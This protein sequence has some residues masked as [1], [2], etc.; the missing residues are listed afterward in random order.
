MKTRFASLF[1]AT[2]LASCSSPQPRSARDVSANGKRV[3]EAE[4]Q[5]D[6]ERFTSRFM[7]SVAET[8]APLTLIED[9]G[10]R[11]LAMRQVLV[12]SSSALEIASGMTPE[13]SLLDMMVFVSLSH[14]LLEKHWIPSVFG[15]RGQPLQD[16]FA[17]AEKDIWKT[18]EKV[19]RTDQQAKLRG[20]VEGYLR[21][22]PNQIRVES[23]R[24]DD[25]S[26]FAGR[27]SERQAKEAGGLFGEVKAA[28]MAADQAVLLGERGL[29][30]AHRM[31]FLLRLQARLG[32][33]E[34]MTD[35]LRRMNELPSVKDALP[36][37]KA[38]SQQAQTL[39]KDAKEMYVEAETMFGAL[40]QLLD[41][42]PPQGEI[43][44]TL[45]VANQ[46]TEQMRTVLEEVRR[47]MPKDA[48][49]TRD[50]ASFLMARGD[51]TV[52]AVMAHADRYVMRWAAYLVAIGAAWNLFFWG[53]Y[54][55][56]KRVMARD[57]DGR[58]APPR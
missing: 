15:D 39:I 56:V 40:G 43:Q 18:S 12:Y 41:R 19:M 50:T 45:G 22:N 9:P 25:F 46:F 52:N 3:T 42:M 47:V 26:V 51:Q 24:F 4:L 14:R 13:T 37:V 54:Y 35:S 55:A 53:G 21:D 33:S 58:A 30:I 57:S 8:S 34:V 7:E 29:Y 32:V 27:V 2:M 31:P 16:A 10:V 5:Q 11:Q 28:T 44:K 6:V 36:E 48:G 20:L 49:K 23:V 17:R 1:V 38:L